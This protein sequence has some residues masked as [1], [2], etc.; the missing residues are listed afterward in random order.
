MAH[1]RGATGRESS[2]LPLE[3]YDAVALVRDLMA[4]KA[5]RISVPE[6]LTGFLRMTNVD[7]S[8]EVEIPPRD[9]FAGTAP[10]FDQLVQGMADLKDRFL[11]MQTLVYQWRGRIFYTMLGGT[12]YAARV[13]WSLPAETGTPASGT[14]VV[15]PISSRSSGVQLLPFGKNPD[16]A[17]RS[18]IRKGG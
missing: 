15:P 12:R 10:D 13:D 14:G 9:G 4:R 16:S 5:I 18:R 8:R 2:L 3:C 1:L 6:S 7:W 17:L 11:G